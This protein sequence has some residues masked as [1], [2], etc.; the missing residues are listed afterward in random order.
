[1][2]VAVRIEDV[3]IHSCVFIHS[4]VM[5]YV[6]TI[7]PVIEVGKGRRVVQGNRGENV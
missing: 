4:I 3:R 1:M 5:S 7:I 2:G 6:D